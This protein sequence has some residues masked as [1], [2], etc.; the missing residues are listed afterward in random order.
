MARGDSTEALA[1]LQRSLEL[2]QQF[3]QT[4]LLLGDLHLSREEWQ[5]AVEAYQQLTNLDPESVPAWSAIG[6]AYSQLGQLDRAIDANNR[7]LQTKPDDY[8]TLKNLALLYG[9]VN[10]PGDAA[11]Y[12]QLALA[13]APEQDKAGLR[14]YI[15]E[16]QAL[17]SGAK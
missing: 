12:A 16:Q 13:G 11:R 15:E 10:N 1:K 9:E 8:N 14:Q 6:Y 17:L 4:F 2:D 5:E 3:T 7:I